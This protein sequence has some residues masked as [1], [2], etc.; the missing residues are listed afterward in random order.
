MKLNLYSVL[1]IK[2][3][4]LLRCFHS[5]KPIFG[6]LILP[7][8][9][10]GCG[11]REDVKIGFLYSDPTYR[12][13]LES[14][15]FAERARE[16]GA[17]V[18]VMSGE[19][20][21]VIQYERALEMIEA[22]VDYLAIIPVN[23]NTAN[24]IV[25]EAKSAGVQV[26]SYTRLIPDSDLDVF[27]ASDNFGSGAA[28]VNFAISKVPRG[29][30]I[31]MGGDKFDRNGVELQSAIDSLLAPKVKSG[32]INILYRTYT[33][34]WDRSYAAFE[35]DQ[36]LN[37]SSELPDVIL[38]AY[39]GMSQAMIEVLEE[40]NLVGKVIMTGQDAELKSIKYIVEGKQHFT[41]S[42]PY[43]QIA[44]K[45]AEIAVKMARG[46]RLD[47]SEIIYINNGFKEVPT[48]QIGSI[49]VTRENIDEVIIKGG[50]YTRAEVYN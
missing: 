35:L 26:M 22:G 50:V 30:Y 28:V 1:K 24:A 18:I 40:H 49:P 34:T 25:R 12:F 44:Y 46:E 19:K 6:L 36:F 8:F 31:L 21:E 27:I 4:R 42:H 13:V 47:K 33:E 32:D 23:A 43:K 39:D 38:S 16:L 11:N 15:Y 37:N 14:E 3:N 5:A 10:L 48:V 20:N 17:E 29:N 9:A 2:T 45:A 7:L 41:L